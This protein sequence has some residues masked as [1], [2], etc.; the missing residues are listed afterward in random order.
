M[1]KTGK[2]IMALILAAVVVA[3]L[4]NAAGAVGILL[5]GGTEANATLSTLEG[6]T[7]HVNN[8]G[9]FT[10]GGTKIHLGG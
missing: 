8:K 1:S 7:K 3:I 9:T 10:A 4:R 6:G 2:I 5:A